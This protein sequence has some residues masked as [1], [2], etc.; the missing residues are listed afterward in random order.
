MKLIIEARPLKTD[1]R[2]LADGNEA[3]AVCI[4]L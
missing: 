4:H 2:S 1:D 3:Y